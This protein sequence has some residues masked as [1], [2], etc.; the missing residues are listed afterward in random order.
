MS[1]GSSQ[2]VSPNDPA[3]G[4]CDAE[5][6]YT[7]SRAA[8]VEGGSLV[9]RRHLGPVTLALAALLGW[10]RPAHAQ[11]MVC[12]PE[13]QKFCSDVPLGGGRVADCLRTHEKE[14]SEACH[15]AL[16]GRAK[17]AA[18]AAEAP[19]GGD[20]VKAECRGDAIKFCREAVG[21][22]ARMKACMQQHAAQLSDG[23]KTALIEHGQ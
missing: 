7:R 3:R 4:A 17:E 12:R 20:D 21:D 11:M 10:S 19:Q 8:N 9:S 15:E 16:Y 1:N 5:A 18:P 2:T 23:C 13:I 22:K 14:L 6:R